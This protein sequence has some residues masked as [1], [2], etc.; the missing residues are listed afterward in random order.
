MSLYSDPVDTHGHTVQD[1]IDIYGIGAM[2]TDEPVT[3]A[4]SAAADDILDTAAPH[5]FVAGDIVVLM[6]KTGGTGVST[7]TAYRVSDTSLAASTFRIK[8][9]EGGADLGFSTDITAGT[10]AKLAAPASDL[11]FEGN[12]DLY[13]AQTADEVEAQM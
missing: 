5:G 12:G 7:A 4:T 10:V 11:A 6:T 13:L 8:A 2:A 1:V 9:L 3:L